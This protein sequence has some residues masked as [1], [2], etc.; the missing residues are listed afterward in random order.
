MPRFQRGHHRLDDTRVAQGADLDRIDPFIEGVEDVVSH[1][2]PISRLDLLQ[3]ALALPR[4]QGFHHPRD[5]AESP[6]HSTIHL[7][8]GPHPLIAAT[9]AQDR[10]HPPSRMMKSA[11]M[12]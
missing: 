9:Q 5:H 1:F 2:H 4:E 7:H 10:R 8:P 11:M 6:A 3:A 12:L